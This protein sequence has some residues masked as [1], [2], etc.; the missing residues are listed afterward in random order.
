MLNCCKATLAC[1]IICI[2]DKASSEVI[3]ACVQYSRNVVSVNSIGQ[4]GTILAH[5]LMHKAVQV[6][7]FCLR[8]QLLIMEFIQLNIFTDRPQV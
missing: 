3:D 4:S 2:H 7:T 5:A 8:Q 6:V 1:I